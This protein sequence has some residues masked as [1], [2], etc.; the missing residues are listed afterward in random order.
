MS[1]EIKS[2]VFKIKILTCLLLCRSFKKAITITDAFQ[3]V[4]DESKRRKA[5][6]KGCK[7]NKIWVDEGSKFYSRSMKSW[8]EKNYVEMYSTHNEGKSVTAE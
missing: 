3:K 1:C 2:I 4:L 5:K 8:L 7:P 6:S